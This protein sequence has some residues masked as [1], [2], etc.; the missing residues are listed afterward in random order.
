MRKVSPF[1]FILLAGLA[2]ILSACASTGNSA[3][4]AGSSWELVS[5]GPV[6]NQ[7]PAVPGVETK[8]DFGKDGQLGGDV[9]CN[10]FGGGYQVKNDRIIFSDMHMT[11]MACPDPETTQESATLQVMTGTVRFH[12]DGN[13]L[14][15]YAASGD[16]AILL[17]K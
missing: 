9:G 10:A 15:I 17:S 3:S 6:G 4:L 8:V 14:T 11:M 16:N 1:S 7:I 13:T 2:L 5:Y 12:L